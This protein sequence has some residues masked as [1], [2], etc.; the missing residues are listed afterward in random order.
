MLRKQLLLVLFILS[1]ASHLL[2][3]SVYA[4]LNQDYYHLIDRFEIKLGHFA[5][6]FHSSAKPLSRKGIVQLV[7]SII[8]DKSIPLNEQEF[9]NLRYLKN[10]NWEWATE[11]NYG[12]SEKNF[13]GKT[14]Y[15]KVSDAYA[16]K[17]KDFEIHA[18]PVFNF[19]FGS[20]SGGNQSSVSL[21]TRGVEIRGMVNQK[22]G[23]YTYL[24]DN[25]SIIPD[26]VKNFVD[27]YNKNNGISA[28]RQLPGM[29]SEGYTKRFKD[30]PYGTDFISSRAYITF[31]AIKS[32]QFQFGHDR[33][34]IGTGFRSMLLSDNAPPYL[35]LKINT[36]IGRFQ[37]Q[38]VFAQLKNATTD[39]SLTSKN[40]PTKYMA[41]H[42][43][44]I[45]VSKKVNIGL[46]ESVILTRKVG[47]G[48]D[49]NYLN[50]VIFYR[51]IESFAGSS[52]N[53]LIGLDIK[54]NLARRMSL[55]GQ[56]M[57]DEFY[58]R[59]LLTGNG[60]WTNKFGF[61]AGFKFI[62]LLGIENL[63]WQSEFNAARPFTYSHNTGGHY[64]HYS[65][66]LAHPLGA[67]FTEWSH[68]VRFQPSNRLSLSGKLIW[69]NF[70][71]DSSLGENVGK[72]I[73]KDYDSR[74]QNAGYFTGNGRNAGTT[75]IDLRA[76]FQLKHNLFIDA[77]YF[78]RNYESAKS[79]LNTNASIFSVGVRLNSGYR[80]MI[81]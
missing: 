71:E 9:F 57:V 66:A 37:Y 41:S 55:Y 44:S 22:L 2:A 5:N 50:P 47:E 74:K 16:Y 43:L 1:S 19:D 61:Q 26:Y 62:N 68:I 11:K 75:I 42:H 14:F 17:D 36:R 67:N 27:E 10:D 12:N 31:Q 76:S 65:Q 40:L 81:F 73:L 77:H 4:P 30:N 29:P 70:G 7:D 45:N 24:S 72:D 39:T 25:Q 80:Q 63:D 34:F 51:S 53:A 20:A 6:G 28:V 13:W 49:I 56:I 15:H 23:F 32:I 52:D 3:Q 58:G 48:F 21:N 78:N 33:N 8:A 18:S 54:A 69:A 64:S 79:T 38:N 60:Y 59:E 35:F 46:F